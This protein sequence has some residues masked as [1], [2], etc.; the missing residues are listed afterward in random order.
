MAAGIAPNLNR[1]FG[2]ESLYDYDAEVHA[3]EREGLAG[4]A[5]R[6]APRLRLVGMEIDRKTYQTACGIRAEHFPEA[7]IELIH[8]DFR[9]VKPGEGIGTAVCNPPYGI[10]IGE[11]ED[12][13]PLYRAL[14][15]FLQREL[16]RG[17]AAIYTA[18]HEAAPLFGGD[19]SNSIPL[20]NG[21]LEGRLYR[22]APGRGQ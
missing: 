4:A 7:P 21:S 18:N 5:I 6:E 12:I 10:R 22:I 19:L 11:E 1:R 3:A 9:N 14:G 13:G 20:L 2:F 16:P 17:Q 15:E 8:G